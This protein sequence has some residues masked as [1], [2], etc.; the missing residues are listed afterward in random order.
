MSIA[1]ALQHACDMATSK[2]VAEA[3]LAQ[4]AKS[5][6]QLALIIMPKPFRL[7]AAPQATQKR[8]LA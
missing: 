4:V 1:L 5:Y 6:E 7:S 3:A 2:E 8:M